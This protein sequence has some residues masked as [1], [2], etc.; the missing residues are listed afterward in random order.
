MLRN[1]T[2]GALFQIF[3]YPGDYK[4]QWETQDQLTELNQVWSRFGCAFLIPQGNV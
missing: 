4:T 1:T 3:L 2:E